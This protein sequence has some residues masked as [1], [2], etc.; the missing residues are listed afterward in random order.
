[1]QIFIKNLTGR[2]I[3][4]EVEP[5]TSIEDLKNKILEKEGTP[6]DEQRLI[7]GGRQLQEGTVAD[8][9]IQNNSSISLVLRLRGGR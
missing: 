3:A 5:E 9:N 7:Y 6:V 2:S 4:F 1:M 8:Y